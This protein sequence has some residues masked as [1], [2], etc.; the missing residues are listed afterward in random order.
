M[1]N[2]TLH[3]AFPIVVAA[4][5]NQFGIKVKVGGDQAYTDGK[6]IQLPAYEGDDADYKDYAWGLL[7][8]ESAHIR[9]S[10]FNLVYGNSVLRRRLAGAIEDVRIEHELAKDFPGTRLTLR[11]VVDK[12][13]ISGGFRV[14]T[15]EDHPANILYGYVLKS[16]RARVLGQ[17]ALNP[18]VEQS[19]IILLK[20][21]PK[22][23]V[24]CL[25]DL[26]SEVPEGLK[27]ESDCLQL[28]DR[29]LA[30][31]QQ[32]VEQEKQQL[33][34]TPTELDQEYQTTEQTE[35]Q[36]EDQS[37]PGNQESPSEQDDDSESVGQS[38]PTKPEAKSVPEVDDD[39]NQSADH[40]SESGPA[41]ECNEVASELEQNDA[42]TEK[43]DSDRLLNA[44][45]SAI[46]SDIDQDVFD[47]IKSVLALTQNSGTEQVMPVGNEP[48]LNERAG[49]LLFNKVQ[50]ES[51][52]IRVALQGL[53]QS[54]TLNRI[55]YSNRGRRIDAKRLHHLALGETKVFLRSAI[56]ASPNT[57]I[58]LLLDKSESMS[59]HLMDSQG[60]TLGT[61]LP[62]AMEAALALALA[63]EGLTGVNPGITAFPGGD[64]SSVYRLLEH[65][66][67]V[68]QRA[69]AFALSA[70]GSTPMTE[71]IWFGASA[72]LQ[73]REPRKVLMVM[74]DG[75]PNDTLST[76]EILQRC[77]DSGIEAVGIGLGIDVSHLFPVAININDYKELRSQLF[78]LSKTVLLAA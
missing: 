40:E 20:T 21:F 29:I 71:A 58:H 7:A 62:I 44:L 26:L 60:N 53:V 37:K 46:D 47:T 52:K 59:Y 19:E 31:L 74:T 25:Q 61:R 73:C 57:A 33:P 69:G 50:S 49:L 41:D 3:H 13:I 55:Q 24:V 70:S 65:G 48:Y 45:L 28:T 67:R 10:D 77:Q 64:D 66:K 39:L 63:L 15:T 14:V 78:E 11:T 5:G 9:Y 34:A 4:I 23:A 36:A 43:P 56:K 8:H 42:K 18:L 27:S 76:L 6:T 1:K 2:N 51:L 38:D 32:E 12:M 72:L 68:K 16:L 75:Q 30:M 54:Q 35:T 17:V 22:A